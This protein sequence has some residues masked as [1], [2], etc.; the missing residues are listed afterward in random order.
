M[1]SQPGE[2]SLWHHPRP[3]E[4]GIHS[5]LGLQ[6]RPEGDRFACAQ[7][8]V[9]P[10]GAGEKDA[11]VHLLIAVVD[12]RVP[13]LGWHACLKHIAPWITLP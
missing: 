5:E 2:A 6:A 8:R 11:L 3:P 13:C 1:V 10:Q 7:C 9:Q 12:S 4:R